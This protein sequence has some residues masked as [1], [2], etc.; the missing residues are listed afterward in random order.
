MKNHDDLIAMSEDEQMAYLH[1]EV[2]KIISSAPPN[3]TLKLR[4][5][6][7]RMDGIRRRIKNP[8]VR[9]TMIVKEMMVSFNELRAVLQAFTKGQ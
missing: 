8:Q 5:L 1:E 3:Q 9:L 6:Q 4:A 2:E 7:A